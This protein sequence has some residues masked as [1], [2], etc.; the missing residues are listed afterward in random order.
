MVLLLLAGCTTDKGYEYPQ[1]SGTLS[2]MRLY[3]VADG[4]F[5][6]IAVDEILTLIEEGRTAIVYMGHA[7]CNWCQ[8]L[9]PVLDE[10]SREKDMKMYYMNF[11][12][13]V[14]YD[15]AEGIF[16]IVDMLTEAGLN[17]AGDEDTFYFPTILYIRQG[18]II[19]AHQGTVNGHDADVAPLSEKQRAR[20]VYQLEKEF[21]GMLK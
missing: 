3:D 11:D 2:D 21:D 4:Q 10:V 14:N 9:V 18:K 5:Y 1:P 17:D 7:T 12:S 8:A 19:N 6:D 15:N 16:R 13:R 20:L